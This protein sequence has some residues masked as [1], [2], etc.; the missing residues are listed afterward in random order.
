MVPFTEETNILKKREDFA[1]SL[2]KTK[3]KKALDQ[4]RR[5][6]AKPVVTN[7]DSNEVYN[8]HPEWKKENYKQQDEIL[9]NIYQTMGKDYSQMSVN[10]LGNIFFMI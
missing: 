4:K 3:T 7:G 8:G 5:R 10:K 2:R 9:Q 6:L 1:I